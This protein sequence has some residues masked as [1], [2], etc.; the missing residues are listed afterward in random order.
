MKA[1]TF[2][3][4]FGDIDEKYIE[5]ADDD[6]EYHSEDAYES[7]VVRAG[8]PRRSFL[9]AVI[10]SVA[11]TA[12]ALFGVFVLFLNIGTIRL[13]ENPE[14]SDSSYM[15]ESVDFVIDSE[16][17]EL[18]LY[19]NVKGAP[20]RY[21]VACKV[22]NG[23]DDVFPYHAECTNMEN[24]SVIITEK[25]TAYSKTIF[26]TPDEPQRNIRTQTDD[27]GIYLEVTLVTNDPERSA[28]VNMTIGAGKAYF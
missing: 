16:S 11:C 12:A 9:S 3:Q 18:F 6:E 5:Q 27:E 8:D 14:Q 23:A 2:L 7:V 26:I 19:H 4:I 28:R 24:C 10:A 22:R 25:N 20:S 15:Y 21:T 13:G 17:A 1:E